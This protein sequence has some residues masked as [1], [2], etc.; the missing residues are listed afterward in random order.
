MIS[1][2]KIPTTSNKFE[3]QI[4]YAALITQSALQF[5]QEI[6]K[7]VEALWLPN[8]RSDSWVQVRL[9]YFAVIAWSKTRPALLRWIWVSTNISLERP[10][11]PNIKWLVDKSVSNQMW[12]AARNLAYFK[13][14][15]ILHIQDEI[16]Y[17]VSYKKPP[18]HI[19]VFR[20]GYVS[21]CFVV[22]LIP[23]WITTVQELEHQSQKI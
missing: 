10:E 5:Y 20:N 2:T 12:I 16:R 23:S 18:R 3:F 14:L 22:T 17:G 19:A 1:L 7:F 4:E 6:K 21:F 15:H 8:E 9:L 11:S 13:L